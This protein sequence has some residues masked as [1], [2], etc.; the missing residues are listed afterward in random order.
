MR[1]NRTSYLSGK[2]IL[3]ARQRRP[4]GSLT[5]GPAGAGPLATLPFPLSG[6]AGRAHTAAGIFLRSALGFGHDDGRDPVR[7]APV[8]GDDVFRALDRHARAQHR[9]ERVEFRPAERLARRGGDADGA[10]V[11]D[12]Q[13]A[14]AFGPRV[15][16]VALARPR[17][18]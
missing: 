3:L 7:A 6:D 1:P 4:V 14:V 18:G 13:V 11:F 10:V 12:Q 15:G 2:R 8:A 17:V 5:G 16:H 9:T